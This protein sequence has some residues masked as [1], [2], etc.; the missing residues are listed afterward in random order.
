[1]PNMQRLLVL[2]EGKF[3]LNL[4]LIGCVLSQIVKVE[5]AFERFP[6]SK[7]PLCFIAQG[8]S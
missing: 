1:M 4:L 2:L 3:Y 7:S 5:T 8:D 6:G